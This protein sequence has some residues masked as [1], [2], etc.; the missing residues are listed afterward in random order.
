VFRMIEGSGMN[1]KRSSKFQI[2]NSQE[3]TSPKFGV[4]N[5]ELGILERRK[6]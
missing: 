3:T 5:L 2:L 1:G 4:W 6:K